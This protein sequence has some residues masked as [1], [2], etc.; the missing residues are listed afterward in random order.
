MKKD[1]LHY[2]RLLLG[3]MTPCVLGAP[4]AS[5]L[6]SLLARSTAQ[7]RY[8]TQLRGRKTTNIGATADIRSNQSV[9]AGRT[10]LFA[11]RHNNIQKSKI[12]IIS[13]RMD[14]HADA[15]ILRL[16]ERGHAP[17]RIHLADF[18]I[19]ASLSLGLDRDGPR[20]VLHTP[21]GSI[22]VQEIRSIWWRKPKAHALSL[23]L[24]ADERS[25]ARREIGHVFGGLWKNIECYWFNHPD[26]IK[27][28]SYKVEQL[29]RAASMGFEVPRTLVTSR[30][31]D[32]RAFYVECGGNVIYKTLSNPM[33]EMIP[34]LDAVTPAGEEASKVT[35]TTLLSKEDFE[36]S[37]ETVKHAPCLFQQYVEKKFEYR[38]TVV[39]N[40]VFVAEIDSQAQE[41]TKID[42]RQYHV[43]RKF[44]AGS[45]PDKLRRLCLKFVRSYDLRF[46]AMDIILT[47]DGRYVFLENN[48]NGQWY[49]VERLVPELKISEAVTECLATGSD[50]QPAVIAPAMDAA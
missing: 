30:P 18:P 11:P 38:L 41:E 8:P 21:K 32:A 50:R 48:P 35:K 42:W 29:R 14:L 2:A 36:K 45:I 13:D 17:I 3:V 5:Q 39:G 22:D 25:F 28:A 23:E 26:Q 19:R 40:E 15:I 12:V 43:L 20:S 7:T 1:A 24:S 37:V 16:R 49:F 9:P 6:L 31:E 47:P 4:M 27:A 33:I 46:S 34:P 44:R 10:A